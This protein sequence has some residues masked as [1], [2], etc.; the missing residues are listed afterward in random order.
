MTDRRPIGALAGTTG[1]VLLAGRVL[2]AAGGEFRL[3]DDTGEIT[4]AGEAR[5]GDLVAV[6]GELAGGRV[7]ARRVTVLTPYRGR[8]P[9][10]SPRSESWR[11]RPRAER[12]RARAQATAAI[13]AFFAS[14]GFLEVE[15]PLRV[16]SPGLEVHLDAQAAPDHWLITSPEY[17][18]KRLLAAGF[19]RIFE[20]CKCFRRD[21]LGSHHSSEFTMLEWYRAFTGYE[22]IAEDTEEL[23]AAVARAV[24]GTTKLTFN[25]ETVDLTPPWERLTVAAALARWAGIEAPGDLPAAELRARALAAGFGPI[26]AGAPWDDVFFQVFVH[27]VEPHLGRGGRP[28]L[29]L[30]WP[31]PLGA[32]A[33]LKPGDPTIALRFEAYACGLE[34]ANAFDELTDPVEQRAR[35]A[36]ELAARRAAGK[37]LYPVDERFVAALEEGLPPCAGIALGVD[38]LVMLCTGA[39]EIREVLA[40]ADDEL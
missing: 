14:R 38:R 23:C 28:T 36:E 24:A 12:L 31:A 3:A 18:M 30:E 4:V 27:A 11:L 16:P 37:P 9:F 19:E 25:G 2:A 34:L 17:Q 7:R 40:F 1:P 33:R 8:A 15:T 29:L 22:T 20:L 35:F 5:P 21:E 32:L 26:A 6:E 10:P 39:T 13:R